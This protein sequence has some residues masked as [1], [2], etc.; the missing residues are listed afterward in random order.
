MMN[1]GFV[2]LLNKPTA[3]QNAVGNVQP[4]DDWGLMLVVDFA[5]KRPLPKKKDMLLQDVPKRIGST[6]TASRRFP[7]IKSK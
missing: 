5:P 4:G 2:L 1:P 6:S 3:H 7:P